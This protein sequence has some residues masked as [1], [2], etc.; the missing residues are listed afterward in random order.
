[1]L[2]PILFASILPAYYAASALYDRLTEKV[3]LVAPNP[4]RTQHYLDV[5]TEMQ[6]SGSPTLRAVP[7][8]DGRW[9]LLE[10]SNRTTAAIGLR[11]RINLV[12]IDPDEVVDVDF[13]VTGDDG[14]CRR[15]PPGPT[16]DF[17]LGWSNPVEHV[18][19]AHRVRILERH[20]RA[21]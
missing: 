3:V 15:C 6:R 14:V 18:V 2:A 12:A 5:V 20:D 17:A 11:R 13:Y 9:I 1:M 19:P 4:T 8:K 21:A 10:G 7:H 16:G